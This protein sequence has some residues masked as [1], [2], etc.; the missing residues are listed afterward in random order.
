LTAIPFS[1]LLA[2]TK[3]LLLLPLLPSNIHHVVGATSPSSPS[4]SS[5]SSSSSSSLATTRR[6]PFTTKTTAFIDS[7]DDHDRDRDR[8]SNSLAT[9]SPAK[10]SPPSSETSTFHQKFETYGPTLTFT[11]RDPIV[12]SMSGPGSR[13]SGNGIVSRNGPNNG[14]NPTGLTS[15]LAALFRIAPS[16][17]YPSDDKRYHASAG[18][19]KSSATSS[20]APSASTATS[21]S[22]SMFR[23]GYMIDDG[24][25]FLNNDESSS[26]SPSLAAPGGSWNAPF[27]PSSHP[28]RKGTFANAFHP[29]IRFRIQSRTARSTDSDASDD[30]EATETEIVPPFP[31]SMPWLSSL[32]CGMAWRPF[33]TYPRHP[34]W[35]YGH[36]L[37]A[38]PH[39]VSCAVKVGLPRVSNRFVPWR[40]SGESRNGGEEGK[41]TRPQQRTKK[42]RH[43]TVDVGITYRDQLECPGGTL[44]ILLGKA[45]NS[46]SPP[47]P[48]SSSYSNKHSNE[49]EYGQEEGDEGSDPSLLDDHHDS[50]RSNNN[51][52]GKNGNMNHNNNNHFLIRLATGRQRAR[53]NTH[54]ASKNIHR[55]TI[56]TATATPNKLDAPSTYL[57]YLRGSLHLPPPFFLRDKFRKGVCLSPS[58]DFVDGRARCVLSGEVGSSGRT[59]AVLR[60][61]AEDSTLTVVRRLDER[62]IIA[63][64]ISLQTGKIVYDW[65]LSLDD[66]HN[67][68]SS[69]NND[70]NTINSNK[71]NSSIRA[72]VDPTK[73]IRVLWTDGMPGRNNHGMGGSCWVTECRIPLGVVAS[74]R[75]L[76]GAADIRVKRRWVV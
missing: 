53:T 66:D 45:R 72:H 33:P 39:H 57:E 54:I 69:S 23:E 14:N 17:Y 55:K 60:L 20:S 32:A 2:L 16:P 5:S 27:P 18:N 10:P 22:E 34:Q 52:S 64:T 76:L 42:G 9:S 56:E 4:A 62:K 28:F 26:P 19:S 48:A 70:N 71:C 1:F 8:D 44:E 30:G 35:G 25:I 12:A 37:L 43:K 68:S 31:K 74:G 41:R 51:R 73:G 13:I 63:P 46:L 38:S 29:E 65:Y 7:D 6:K 36:K 50:S 21:D 40:R 67:S 75:G 58:Y 11:L 59:M 24:E 3:F 49:L 61:D 47:S 15:R